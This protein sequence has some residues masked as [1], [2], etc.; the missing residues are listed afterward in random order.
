MI[1]YGNFVFVS[2]EKNERDGKLYHSLNM[3]NVESGEIWQFSAGDEIVSRM[4][5]YQTYHCH[6][7]IRK[8]TYQGQQKTS[9]SLAEV[10]AVAPAT[11]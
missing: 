8:Y 5:K 2:D 7:N 10:D 3:E 6:L 4:K 1:T 9:F 11:K